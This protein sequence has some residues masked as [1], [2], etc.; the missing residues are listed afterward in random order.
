MVAWIVVKGDSPREVPILVTRA[1]PDTLTLNNDRV[2]V[3]L[4]NL[5]ATATMPGRIVSSRPQVR[6]HFRPYNGNANTDIHRQLRA[7]LRLCETARLP[8]G[9]VL[10][11]HRV[12][13]LHNLPLRY[14]PKL[15]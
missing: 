10:A 14:F 12:D 2:L 4:A 9:D 1:I 15:G 3:R 5:E 11:V 8:T 7:R 6:A 13:I